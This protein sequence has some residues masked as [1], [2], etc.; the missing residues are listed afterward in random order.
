[1]NIS[2]SDDE[3]PTSTGMPGSPPDL[4]LS[5]SKS[6]KSSF[7]SSYQSDDNGILADADNFEDIGLDDDLKSESEIGDFVNDL[8]YT[9]PYTAERISKGLKKTKSP[10]VIHRDLTSK[11]ARPAYP[12]LKGHVKNVTGTAEIHGLGLMPTLTT[13]RTFSSSTSSLTNPRNRINRSPSPA[14]SPHSLP[15]NRLPSFPK[16]RRGSWQSNRERKSVKQ[17]EKEVDEEDGDEVPDECFLENVPISPRPPN[18]RAVSMPATPNRP[19]IPKPKEKIRPA[20][21]GTPAIPVAQGTLR[22]PRSPSSPASNGTRITSTRFPINTDSY[23]PPRA[24]SWTAALSELSPEVQALTEALE[25]HADEQKDPQSNPKAR[26]RNSHPSPEKPRAKSLMPDI[27]PL[28]RNDIMI[29]PLPISKEKEAVLSRTRPSWL[30]PKD[31]AE[32]KRH[33]KEYARMMALSQQ[34]EA[35]RAAE[36]KDRRECRDD[37]ASS[38]GR[39][40]EEHV[41]P[42]W[43]AV[44]SFKRTREL[45]WRGIAPRSRGKVWARAVGNELG[46]SDVSYSAALKRAREIEK[47]LA[48]GAGSNE[49]RKCGEWFAAIR[50]DMS[51]TFPDLRIFLPGGPLSDALV[52][53]MMAYVVY[54]SDV[55][56]VSGLNVSLPFFPANI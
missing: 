28:R 12:S 41:M 2:S 18:E 48:K 10:M 7:H 52:D 55:G 19:P 8:P 24:K 50:Q 27:P 49:D 23:R 43:D 25:A 31:P 53:V 14:V 42:N 45:W 26:A 15:P 33:L 38:L 21:N 39:I 54:R 1:M 51:K 20:G 22:S 44:V 32:E 6:S 5:S 37:T 56:Y 47:R 13:R 9:A 29:D 35:K 46:L 30:P 4:S 40:W 36:N 11:K 34:A 16:A 17:L 3:S